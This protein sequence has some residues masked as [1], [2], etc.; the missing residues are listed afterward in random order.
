[1]CNEQ[2]FEN[3]NFKFFLQEVL[4]KTISVAAAAAPSGCHLL[5]P[6]AKPVSCLSAKQCSKQCKCVLA[7]YEGGIFIL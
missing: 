7:D 2:N 5:N 6:A 1:M 3:K 4:L